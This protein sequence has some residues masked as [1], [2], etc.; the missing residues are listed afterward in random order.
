MNILRRLALLV[1]IVLCASLAFAAAATAAGGTKGAGPGPLAPGDY[2]TTV[3]RAD[4][5]FGQQ[6]PPAY[7]APRAV[8]VHPPARRSPSPLSKTSSPFNLRRTT[9]RQ[10]R[11]GTLR[12]SSSN[13]P[14][15]LPV[16]AAVL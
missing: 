5:L 2:V 11:R 9:I 13:S 6:G 4:A 12:P 16:R 14:T 8:R 3:T 1:S 7:Q 15:H 10:Q